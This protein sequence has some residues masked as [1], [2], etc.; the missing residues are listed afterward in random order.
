MTITDKNY[1]DLSNRVYWLD[2][3]HSEYNPDLK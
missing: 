1:K 2:P 3:K